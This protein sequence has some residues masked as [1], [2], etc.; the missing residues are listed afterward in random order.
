[1]SDQHKKR[2]T[3]TTVL[4]GIAG[5]LA[6][7]HQTRALDRL[8]MELMAHTHCYGAALSGRTATIERGMCVSVRNLCWDRGGLRYLVNII[9]PDA[10]DKT[11]LI[12]VD[13]LH[14]NT[15]PSCRQYEK[16]M[17][18]RDT[19]RVMFSLPAGTTAV[20]RVTKP[21]GDN[22]FTFQTDPAPSAEEL[23][24]FTVVLFTHHMMQQVNED[25]TTDLLIRMHGT[26]TY[27]L[28]NVLN[29]TLW[30]EEQGA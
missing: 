9:D 13:V 6:E 10:E 19:R 15:A 26:D 27:Y 20:Y 2:Q 30:L 22:S 4:T 18:I 3:D 14:K 12:D 5:S 8:N 16:L 11:V 1:M 23:R 25:P 29:L 24:G 17:E 21:Q 7:L 28:V